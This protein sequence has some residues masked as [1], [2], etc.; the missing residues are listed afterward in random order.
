M[1]QIAPSRENALQTYYSTLQV[2]EDAGPEVIKGAYRFL[3]QKWHPDKNLENIAGAEHMSRV[4]N[5][6]YAILCDPASRA[7]YDDRLR[8]EREAHAE[9]TRRAQGSRD[10]DWSAHSPNQEWP[11]QRTN[12]TPSLPPFESASPLPARMGILK[13]AFLV[14]LL[15]A[16]VAM[17]LLIAYRAISDG[18]SFGG[19]M[20][21]TVW[22]SVGRYAYARLFQPRNAGEEGA[23]ATQQPQNSSPRARAMRFAYVVALVSVPLATGTLMTQGVEF[24]VS[25]LF[26]IFIAPVA[27]LLSWV[28]AGV[29]LSLTTS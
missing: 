19:F 24:G 12:S 11:Q 14:L 28:A 20:V 4:I 25:A 22:L 7:E 27:G 15:L 17:A 9:K 1:L 5:E 13:H 29:Y 10:S 26:S 21:L 18:F 8:N 23:Q 3:S 6:A 2:V 16:A